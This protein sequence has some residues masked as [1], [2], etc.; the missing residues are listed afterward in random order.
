[1]LLSL[2]LF[3]NNFV[4]IINKF[5]FDLDDC[6]KFHISDLLPALFRKIRD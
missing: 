5:N 3:K 6:F 2:I 1:M 4:D